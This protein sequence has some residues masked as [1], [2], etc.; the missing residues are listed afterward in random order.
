MGSGSSGHVEFEYSDTDFLMLMKKYLS[1]HMQMAVFFF[2]GKFSL[3]SL[4]VLPSNAPLAMLSEPKS[5]RGR[6]K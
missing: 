5:K 3:I 6:N 4:C 1:H 2:S